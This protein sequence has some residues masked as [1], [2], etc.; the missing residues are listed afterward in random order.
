[1]ENPVGPQECL[2]N[3]CIGFVSA[4]VGRLTVSFIDT[5][6]IQPGGGQR[7]QTH[8]RRGDTSDTTLNFDC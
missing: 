1:M 7:R 6:E 2:C 4:P 3:M 5:S 8:T